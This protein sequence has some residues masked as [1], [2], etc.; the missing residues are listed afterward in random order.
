MSTLG[1]AKAPR[2]P[3]A[4]TVVMPRTAQ[5]GL[6]CGLVPKEESGRRQERLGRVFADGCIFM[7]LRNAIFGFSRELSACETVDAAFDLGSKA[8]P[9]LS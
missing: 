1:G 8:Q 3:N 2:S 7:K 6:E 9:L 4:K 5:F